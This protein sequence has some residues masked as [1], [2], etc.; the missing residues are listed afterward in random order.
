MSLGTLAWSSGRPRRV[1]PGVVPRQTRR[2]IT[3]IAIALGVATGIALFVLWPRH[4]FTADV[5]KLGFTKDLHEAVVTK[6]GRGPCNGTQGLPKPVFC[7]RVQFRL[8]GG[9]DRG[10]H[11][12]IE[13]ARTHLESPRSMRVIG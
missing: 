2:R 11:R 12:T 13:F 8:T 3:L 10:E 1:E 9:P 6:V 4:D 7:D 5:A